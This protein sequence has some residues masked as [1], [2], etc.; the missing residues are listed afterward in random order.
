MNFVFKKK[1]F[2]QY[3][4]IDS[5]RNRTYLYSLWDY[6]FTIKLYYLSIV[7]YINYLKFKF[8]KL[9]EKLLE[10]KLNTILI[11][12]YK[13]IKKLNYQNYKYLNY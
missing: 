11:V 8:K 13:I 9:L 12:Y 7:H 1:W 6:R 2:K 10:L 4:L 3:Y 5:N